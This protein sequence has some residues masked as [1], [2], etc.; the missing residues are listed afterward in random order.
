MPVGA[1]RLLILR[2]WISISNWLVF[3]AEEDN[4]QYVE[5]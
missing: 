2:D 5:A 4:I 1:A 3:N